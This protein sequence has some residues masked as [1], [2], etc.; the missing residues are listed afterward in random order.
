MTWCSANYL[1]GRL[2]LRLLFIPGVL[3]QE[4]PDSGVDRIDGMFCATTVT[5]AIGRAFVLPKKRNTA[6]LASP[7]RA[8]VGIS[9]RVRIAL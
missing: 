8:A 4:S 3:R 7:H 6:Q 1:R 9:R 5:V 2:L